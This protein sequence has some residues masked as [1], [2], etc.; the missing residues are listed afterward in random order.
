M[1]RKDMKKINSKAIQDIGM[2][3]NWRVWFEKNDLATLPRTAAKSAQNDVSKR[4]SA[5]RAMTSRMQ[6]GKL[7][8]TRM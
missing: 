8:K 4:G 2:Y 7:K 5:K 1:V 3:Q 6:Y